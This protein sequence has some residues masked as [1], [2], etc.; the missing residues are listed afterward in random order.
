MPSSIFGWGDFL[1]RASAGLNFFLGAKLHCWSKC[2]KYSGTCMTPLKNSYVQFRR[3]VSI[4]GGQ[5]SMNF[6]ILNR[7]FF[8]IFFKSKSKKSKS[9]KSQNFDP[10]IL[11]LFFIVNLRFSKNRDFFEKLFE[12][13]KLFFCN[14]KNRFFCPQR[15]QIMS[16]CSVFQE[17]I[18][19]VSSS[20]L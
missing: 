9:K 11:P 12:V 19:W 5:N 14:K 15:D 10:T 18:G 16:L 17:L 4:L 8:W 7:D 1:N 13:L 6:R 2:E 20:W 3:M